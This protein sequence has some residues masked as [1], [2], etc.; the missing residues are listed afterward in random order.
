MGEPPCTEL[1]IRRAQVV[2]IAQ[3]I[4]DG[5]CGIVE[6]ARQLA[7]IRLDVDPGEEDADFRALLGLDAHS[8]DLPTGDIRH[9]WSPTVLASTDAELAE[10]EPEFREVAMRTCR[11]LVVRYSQSA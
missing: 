8:E 5:S 3:R 6:G 11:A 2:E 7:A 4:L 9:F 10:Y 1:A